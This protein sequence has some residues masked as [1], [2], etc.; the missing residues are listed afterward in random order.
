MGEG[1][2]TAQGP[3]LGHIWYYVFREL[4]CLY[5]CILVLATCRCCM[6]AAATPVAAGCSLGRT[7]V[8]TDQK[9]HPHSP[10]FAPVAGIHSFPF[11]LYLSYPLTYYTDR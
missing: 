1:A 8:I 4:L 5:A 10:G 2:V 9:L 11:Q 7:T 6:A 3:H